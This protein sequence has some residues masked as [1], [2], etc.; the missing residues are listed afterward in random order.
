LASDEECRPGLAGHLSRVVGVGAGIACLAVRCRPRVW[1]CL[2]AARCVW[3]DCDG[4]HARRRCAPLLLRAP[5]VACGGFVPLPVAVLRLIP[6]AC[7]RSDSI[8]S[9]SALKHGPDT[10]HHCFPGHLPRKS[11]HQQWRSLQQAHILCLTLPDPQQY[12]L[13]LTTRSAVIGSTVVLVFPRRHPCA[14]GHG[15]CLADSPASGSCRSQPS[16]S[17]PRTGP[18]SGAAAKALSAGGANRL[19]PRLASS[20]PVAALHAWAEPQPCAVVAHHSCRVLTPRM[21]TWTPPP[22]LHDYVNHFL[23]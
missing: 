20:S 13:N 23:S 4:R 5:P 7:R 2:A 14:A 16:K 15:G 19:L 9:V 8:S 6:E 12:W 21:S 10:Q 22:S 3:A 11:K 18:R 17:P 1:Q